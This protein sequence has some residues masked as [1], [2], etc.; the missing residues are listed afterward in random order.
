M[1]SETQIKQDTLIPPIVREQNLEPYFPQKKRTSG[2]F[3]E[4]INDFEIF[5]SG[6]NNHKR[7]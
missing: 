1:K 2:S 7:L 5:A 6:D 4:L 3:S